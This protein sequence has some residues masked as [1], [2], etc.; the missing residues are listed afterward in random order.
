MLLSDD[1]QLREVLLQAADL[2]PERRAEFLD[3]ACAG[4]VERIREVQSLLFR[5]ENHAGDN[6]APSPAPQPHPAR[7]GRYRIDDIVGEGGMG[8]VYRAEQEQPVRRTVALK[9]VKLGMDTRQVVARFDAERQAL[10]MMDHPHIAKVFDAGATDGGRPYFVMEWVDGVPIT[11]YCEQ[12]HLTLARRLGLFVEVCQ[13]VQHAH[14]KGVIH[15]DVKPANVLVAEV[16]GRPV[17][18][19]I[20]FGIAKATQGR[21]TEQALTTQSPQW[22]GTPRYMSPEQTDGQS[23]VDTRSDVYGLGVLLYEL[24]TGCT[25][26]DFGTGGYSEVQRV[27]REVEPP[28]PSARSPGRRELKGDLDRIVLKAMEKDRSRR[29]ETALGLALD[30]QRYLRHEPVA[31]RQAGRLYRFRKL[32]RRNRL[33]FASAA[34]LFVALAGGLVATTWEMRRAV[35]AEGVQRGMTEDA[36]AKAYASDMGGAQTALSRSNYGRVLALL[37]RHRPRNGATDRRGWEWRYLWAQCRSDASARLFKAEFRPTALTVS[38]DGRWVAIG[39]AEGGR[40]TVIGMDRG[41]VVARPPAGE[42]HVHAAFSPTEPLLAYT[43]VTTDPAGGRRAWLHICDPHGRAVGSARP[44]NGYSQGVTFSSDGRTLVT[45]TA[46]EEG[47]AALWRVPDLTPLG[48]GPLAQHYEFNAT[49]FAVAPDAASAAVSVPGGVRVVDLPGGKLRWSEQTG[50][51]WATPVAFS[52][53][54]RIVAFAA[55]NAG[56]IHLRDARDGHAL[57]PPLTGHTSWIGQLVFWP[58]GKTL[59]SGSADQSIRL[60]DLSDPARPAPIP[61]PL[62][63]HGQEVWRLA[64]LPDRRTLVSAARDGW[65]FRWDCEEAREVTKDH[66]AIQFR[67]WRFD[68]RGAL[69]TLNNAGAVER[70]EEADLRRPVPVMNLGPDVRYAAFCG[71][72]LVIVG[73]GATLSAVDIP[74]GQVVDSRPAPTQRCFMG[75]APRGHWLIQTPD[76]LVH[77]WD[78]RG[79]AELAPL[80]APA[81]PADVA[82]TSDGRRRLAIDGDGEGLLHDAA[83]GRSAAV[84]IDARAVSDAAFSPK[85]YLL[86]VSEMGVV[87]IWQTDRLTAGGRVA[88]LVKLPFN[89]A[90]H[91]VSFSRDGSRLVATGDDAEAVKLYDVKSLQELFTLEATG[92]FDSAGVSPD[93]NLIAAGN[94]EGWLHVWRAPTWQEVDTAEAADRAASTG[95]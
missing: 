91:A 35:F 63:G 48:S 36:E 1:P 7:I 74:T 62:R 31:A 11:R 68:A 73:K 50:V 6:Q 87:G 53:D 61:R 24:L 5:V 85:N 82:Y 72:G 83:T 34:A 70:R 93:G 12:K 49:H 42:F 66:V 79:R 56:T 16:D 43:A 88:A 14:T 46:N 65:V 4:D 59:A 33:A 54:G 15:R 69:L 30:V 10:A 3:V 51:V 32:V 52:G 18:K 13:A 86:A 38:Y 84:A 25:P 71:D 47:V 89:L 19:V 75:P 37:D 40:L 57:G 9:L 45:G 64:L 77:E 28:A 80:P 27:I 20:D 41:E 90:P 23:D 94:Q 22:V 76:H 39:E 81:A 78:P 26:F 29:Y 67:D 44:L 8:T 92:S 58:D 95:R 55:G 2:P 60:W 17:P 21:L